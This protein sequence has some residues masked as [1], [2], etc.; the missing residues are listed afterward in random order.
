MTQ[1]ERDIDPPLDQDTPV[2]WDAVEEAAR[3]RG[4]L[5]YH[6]KR[7]NETTKGAN[8]EMDQRRSAAREAR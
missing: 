1:P 2:D 4:C 3:E 6:R 8:D 7:D 5:E